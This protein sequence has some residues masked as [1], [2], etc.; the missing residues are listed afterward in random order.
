MPFSEEGIASSV[1]ADF[2]EGGALLV[3]TLQR[4]ILFLL[5]DT[6]AGHRSAANAIGSAITLLSQEEHAHWS[7]SI[8]RETQPSADGYEHGCLIDTPSPPNYRIEIVDVFEQCSRFPL[9]EI[10][11]LYAPMIRLSPQLHGK[12]FQQMN[13]EAMVKAATALASP[14]IRSGMHHLMSNI[15]PDVIV[16]VHPVLNYI[17][18]QVLSKLGVPIPFVTVVTDLISVHTA[19]FA[20]GASGYV[21]PTEQAKAFSTQKGIDSS[22]VHVIGLPIH[23]QFT[24][25]TKQKDDVSERLGLI[26]HLP[27]VL[28]V[29]GGEGA[30]GL[31]TAV[32]AISQARLPIQ[33]LV[34]AGRNEEL[35]TRLQRMRSRIQTPMHLFGFVDN[36]PDLMRIADVIVT[37][38]GPGT[39]CEALACGLPIILCGHVPGP[40]SGNIAFVEHNAVGILAQR[41]REIV[42]ELRRLLLPGSLLLP[43][44]Q[45]NALRLSRPHA[46]FAIG[47]YILNHLPP[48]DQ[49]GLWQRRRVEAS[50]Q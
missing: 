38:A 36:M 44:R 35:H 22:L 41:P 24:C 7:E 15:E 23:P 32:R 16:S 47:Q 28:L 42:D 21:V 30:G 39:I 49:P 31:Y 34:V 8:R 2:W 37:K 40:E 14:F 11:K 5:A 27:V 3:S 4:T 12:F 10:V 45:E 46:A 33:L 25:T 48:P 17:T 20:P 26:P 43:H 18:L 1:V 6:G 13:H 29:G 50:R 19:W 9:R